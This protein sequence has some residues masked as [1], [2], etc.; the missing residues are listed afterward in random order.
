VISTSS[1]L[2]VV[3]QLHPVSLQRPGFLMEVTKVSSI[4][5]TPKQHKFCLKYVEGG[6][7]SLAYREVYNCSGSKPSTVSRKAKELLDN[8]KITATINELSNM[9]QQRH[10]VTID[11][12]SNQLD[13]DRIFARQRGHSAAAVSATMGK[14]RL[15]GLLRDRSEITNTHSL[16]RDGDNAPLEEKGRLIAAALA[17]CSNVSNNTSC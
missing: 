6:N 8:G 5:L 16:S 4:I 14:A 10:Q 11:S 17:R 2:L 12:L 1:P 15:F 3:F 13:E 9:H 7:A